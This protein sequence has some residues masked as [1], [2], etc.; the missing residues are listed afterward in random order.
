MQYEEKLA[1]LLDLKIIKNEDI[2]ELYHSNELV[3]TI[4]KEE[5]YYITKININ[6]FHFYKKRNIHDN[7]FEY[8]FYIDLDK[9]NRIFMEMD[10]GIDPILTI[11]S[12]ERDLI[13]FTINSRELS[14]NYSTSLKN[15]QVLEFLKIILDTSRDLKSYLGDLYRYEVQVKSKNSNNRDYKMLI[16]PNSKGELAVIQNTNGFDEIVN[17]KGSIREALIKD[18]N[19]KDVFSRFRAY[20]NNLL[21]FKNDFLKTFLEERG[22]KNDVFSV[23]YPDL[24]DKYYMI[25][26]INNHTLIG[27]KLIGDEELRS[28]ATIIYDLKDK[29]DFGYVKGFGDYAGSFEWDN[30]YV[31][32]LYP[33]GEIDSIFDIKNRIE[34]KDKEL[35][36]KLYNDY[37]NP[38]V[39]RI[40]K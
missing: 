20:V 18:D 15:G 36:E 9:N 29:Y 27:I 31:Y 23:L 14:L 12:K 22:I 38:K 1:R 21:P 37:K 28:H 13:S 10:L 34:I 3:G 26:E 16:A 6:N 4:I 17:V 30:D 5:D 35:K 40:S 7:N 8:N 11:Y 33:N 32:R 24:V 25:K 2:Y 19:G 39:K